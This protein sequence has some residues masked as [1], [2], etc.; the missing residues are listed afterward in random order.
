MTDPELAKSRLPGHTICLCRNG[1]CRFS[2]KRGIA[3]MMELI[4]G[5]VDLTGYS[6][7]DLIVGKAAALL[8][9]RSGIVSVY[10]EVLSE[11]GKAV[12][13]RAGIPYEYGTLTERIVNREGTGI[14]PME[15]AVAGT[16]DPD[17]AYECL[18]EAIE[19]LR[20]GK[21]Q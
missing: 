14:C 21:N 2:E 17:R 1:E 6:V 15:Q 10:A 4:A 8:F 3:P 20:A 9:V 16:D 7:A 11:G 19:R 13:E 5:G 18:T 12:L